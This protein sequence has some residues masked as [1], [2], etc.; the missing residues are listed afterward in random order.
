VSLDREVYFTLLT[1]GEG[2]AEILA[3]ARICAS[4]THPH[5]V[6][7][8]DFGTV[9][10]RHFL[11]TEWVEG[12]SLADIVARGGP[13]AEERTLEIAFAASQALD[14]AAIEGLHHGRLCPEAIV[15]ARGGN[16][17]VRGFGPD[18]ADFRPALDWRSPET[19]KGGREDVRSDVWSLGAVLYWILSGKHPHDDAP[20]AEVVDG[21]V[22]EPIVPLAQVHRRLQPETYTIIDRMLAAAPED[23]FPDAGALTAALE[24]L[25]QRIDERVSLRPGRAARPGRRSRAGRVRRGRR[26]R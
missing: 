18:R 26:R 13:V 12:P 16:P 14:Q 19:K 17:K 3:Q 8:I 6:S 9:K 7:G 23:R 10:N 2:A 22:F 11:V 24:H 25:L 15:I 5:L 4:L 21:E 1:A 20:P